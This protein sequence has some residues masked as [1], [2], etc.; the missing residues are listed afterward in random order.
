MNKVC[1]PPTSLREDAIHSLASFSL[2]LSSWYS[3]SY[4]S[5]YSKCKGWQLKNK[6]YF[7]TL[8][9]RAEFLSN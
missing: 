4:S 9:I 3:D 6:K 7:L 5:A 8:G 2:G 1:K